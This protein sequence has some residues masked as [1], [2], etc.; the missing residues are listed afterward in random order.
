[1]FEG[2]LDR[3]S[4]R[5]VQTPQ[6]FKR[7]IIQKAHLLAEQNDRSDFSDDCSLIH[8]YKLSEIGFVKG[9]ERNLKITTLNDLIYARELL[10]R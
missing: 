6:G 10:N 7:E 8:E 2:I 1:M 9:D 4:L 3:D 5:A